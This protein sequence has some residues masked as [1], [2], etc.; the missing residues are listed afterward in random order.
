MA[1]RVGESDRTVTV[2]RYQAQ[3]ADQM[4][5]LKLLATRQ[6]QN[7]ASSETTHKASDCNCN[8]ASALAPV[9]SFCLRAVK[10]G[11]LSLLMYMFKRPALPF[12]GAI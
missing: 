12:D 10:K 2:P 1:L 7:L 5:G 9:W 3:T 8:N 4:D 11:I 6:V